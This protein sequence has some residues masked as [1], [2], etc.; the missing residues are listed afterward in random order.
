MTASGQDRQRVESR[1]VAVEAVGA[2]VHAIW[3]L[4]RA[5][6]AQVDALA[7][8][9][10]TYLD[11][12]DDTL[13]RRAGRSDGPPADDVLCVVLGPERS[14]C[15]GLPR[16]VA[17]ALDRPGL[18]VGIVG[19]RLAEA[20]AVLRGTAPRVE[21][22]IGGPSSVDDLEEVSEA[23]AA[24]VLRY[25][26]DAQVQ[27]WHPMA[28]RR[29]LVRVELLAGAR[30]ASPA[31]NFETYSPIEH[32]LE[33]AVAEAVVGRVRVGLAETLRAEVRARAV[34]SEH[35]RNTVSRQH[36]ELTD[37]LRVLH[38]E[39]VTN[40]LCELVAARLT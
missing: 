10:S 38:Q 21:F 4:A 29:D 16:Q 31:P 27:L 34:A 32:I 6:L 28:G 2:V 7:P 40:E 14:F 8:E 36:Q 25:A 20:V 26:G 24:Q 1:I 39:A 3:A 33:L 11:W 17:D 35:A 22:E 9:A 5:Q 15:G 19:R 18:R 13:G 23:V 12:L 37:A 30:T